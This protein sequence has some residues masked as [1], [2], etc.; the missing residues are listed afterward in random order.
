M[1]V[2][3]TG[4]GLVSALGNLEQTW[5]QLLA[6]RTGIQRRQPFPELPSLPLGLIDQ[7]PTHLT[8]LTQQLLEE[9]LQDAGLTPPVARLWG[10]RG[11]ESP[12][13]SQVGVL[14]STVP[15]G[16]LGVSIQWAMVRSPPPSHGHD[17]GAWDCLHCS[18]VIADGGVCNGPV[19]DRPRL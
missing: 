10:R 6:G 1:D 14:G 12:P 8:P 9:A 16:G 19:G 18:S 13:S 3:I 4:I 7:M 17:G 5:G 2:V 11:L 15:S